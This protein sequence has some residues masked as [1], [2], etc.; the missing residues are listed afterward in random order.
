[1]EK[2]KVLKT[3]TEEEREMKKLKKIIVFEITHED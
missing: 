3:D 2:I 1:L